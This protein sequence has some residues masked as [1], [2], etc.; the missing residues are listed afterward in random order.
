MYVLETYNG[1]E[2]ISGSF[3]KFELVKVSGEVFR[4]DKII[5]KRTRNGLQEYFVKWKGFT[6][7]YNSWINSTDVEQKFWIFF[8][9]CPQM[10]LNVPHP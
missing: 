6:D 1:D 10:Y 5:K 3:Y 7:N 8:L 9:Q 4:I 2:T